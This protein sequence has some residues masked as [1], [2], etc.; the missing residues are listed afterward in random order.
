MSQPSYDKPLP[1]PTALAQPFWDGLRD[2]QL[3]LQCCSDCQRYNHPPKIICPACHSRKLEWREVAPRGKVYSYTVV[4]R[5]PVPAF[6]E[7]LPYSVALVDIEETGVRLLARL[8]TPVEEIEV[9]MAVEVT[10]DAVT[11]DFSLFGFRAPNIVAL[12][13]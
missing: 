12:K 13:A 2:N 7:D 3:Q 5:A 11:P 4:Y 1:V 8:N 6:K 9:G 10:F